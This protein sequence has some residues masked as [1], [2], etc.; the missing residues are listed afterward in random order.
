MGNKTISRRA[1]CTSLREA[2]AEQVLRYVEIHG[3]PS[4]L[5]MVYFDLQRMEMSRQDIDTAV[6]DLARE[7]R[8]EL[9]ANFAGVSLRPVPG[10]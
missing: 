3:S 4:Q 10:E 8:L 7:G 9:R 6:D 1:P 5:S 2:R